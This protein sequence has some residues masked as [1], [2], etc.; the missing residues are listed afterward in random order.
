M[1]VNFSKFTRVANPMYI[2]YARSSLK[3][4]PHPGRLVPSFLDL[5]F[6]K[7]LE[8]QILTEYFRKKTQPR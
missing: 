6:R 4:P 7:K 3:D 5:T 1:A 2:N 8:E